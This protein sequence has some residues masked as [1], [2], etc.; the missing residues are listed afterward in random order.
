MKR[1]DHISYDDMFISMAAIA[2]YRS[3]DPNTQ[4]GCVIT[5]NDHRVV[6]LGYNGFPEWC[7]DDIFPWSSPEK[8]DYAEHAERNA[9]YNA[10]RLGISTIG[11][12]LYLYSERGYYPCSDCAR[13]IIQSGIKTVI[14][15]CAQKGEA[16]ENGKYLWEPT[17]RMFIAADVQLYTLPKCEKSFVKIS[18]KLL[19]SSG[20]I[21]NTTGEEDNVY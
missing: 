1:L 3:K 12:K 9:I 17:K 21:K 20:I 4:N 6:S 10:T 2:S 19:V 15:A 7:S 16:S 8:Y 13:A 14:M 18:N 11:C 5:T